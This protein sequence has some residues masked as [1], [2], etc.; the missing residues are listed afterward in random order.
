L[1]DAAAFGGM[2]YFKAG[3]L[4]EKWNQAWPHRLQA[5]EFVTNLFS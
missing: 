1:K 2:S 3:C 4:G 5:E